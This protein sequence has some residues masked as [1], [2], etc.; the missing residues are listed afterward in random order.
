MNSSAIIAGMIYRVYTLSESEAFKEYGEHKESVTFAY[1]KKEEERDKIHKHKKRS[2]EDRG[3]R[4]A[5]FKTA[6]GY[7]PGKAFDNKERHQS[8][9]KEYIYE[10]V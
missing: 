7:V 1:D 8:V 5:D 4:S 3:K 6:K 2:K 10:K 9:K